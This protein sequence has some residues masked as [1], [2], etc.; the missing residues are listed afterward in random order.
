MAAAPGTLAHV[1]QTRTASAPYL[2]LLLADGC[3]LTCSYCHFHAEQQ[4]SAVPEG[5]RPGRRVM[6]PELVRRAIN[7]FAQCVGERGVAHFDLSL[8]GGEPLVN[9]KGLEAALAAVQ[10]L[11]AGGLSLT[12]IVNTNATL[13]TAALA[14]RLATLGARAHVSLDGPDLESNAQRRLHS[15]AAS[16][17][18]ALRGLV[19][20]HQAGVAMQLNVVITGS[21]LHRL[22]AL[23]ERAHEAGCDQVFLALPDDPV[24]QGVGQPGQVLPALMA[25]RARAL[26]LGISVSGPWTSGSRPPGEAAALPV[27]VVVRPDGRVFRPHFPDRHFEHVAAAIAPDMQ[28]QLQREWR[29][30]CAPCR[31]CAIERECRGYLRMMVRYHAGV[32]AQPDAECQLARGAARMFASPEHERLRTALHLAATPQQDGEWRLQ[33]PAWP[34]AGIEVS[35]GVV[36]LLDFFLPGAT[37]AAAAEIFDAEALA[38]SLAELR[39]LGALQPGTDSDDLQRFETLAPHEAS[40]TRLCGLLLGAADAPT[41]ATAQALAPHLEQA[42]ACLPS[43]L[44]PVVDP[45][46]V[47]IAA[48]AACFARAAQLP[49]DAPWLRWMAGTVASSV[50]VLQGPACVAVLRQGGRTRLRVFQQQLAHELAHVA[51]RQRGLRVPT[52]LEEGLCEWASGATM[53]TERLAGALPHAEAF[54][55]F[56]TACLAGAE[57][58]SPASTLLQFSELPVDDNPGYRLAHDFVD[59]LVRGLGQGFDGLLDALLARGLRGRSAAFPLHAGVQGL[60]GQDLQSLLAAWQAELAARLRPP[61]Q[62]ARPMRLLAFGSRALVYHR[63]IGGPVELDPATAAAWPALQE[64]N[65]EVED[66]EALVRPLPNGPDLLRRWRAGQLAPRRGY[67]LRLTIEGGCNMSCSYCYEGDKKRQAMSVETA[68]RAVAAWRDLLEPRDLPGSTIRVFGGEPFLNWPLMQHLF[69]TATAGLPAGAVRWLVNTNGT[70]IHHEQVAALQALGGD[71]LVYLSMDG[72]GAVNDR[73][74][75]FRNQRGSFERV[76]RAARALVAARVP[77]VIAVTLTPFNAA[78]LPALLD[79]VAALRYQHP[80]APLSVG[81]KPVIGPALQPGQAQ[82]MLQALEAAWAQGRR[83]GLPV[84]GELRVADEMLLA[85]STPTG[86]FCGVTGRELYVTPAGGLMVCH[87]VPDSEYADL[88]SVAAEHRIPVPDDVA[89]RHAGGMAGCAGCEVEGLCGGGCMAQSHAATG[90]IAGKPHDDFCLM[91]RATFRNGV[92]R[93]LEDLDAPPPR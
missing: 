39:L 2:R 42:V 51:L 58:C 30:V 33:H 87:A 80:D 27:S 72:V 15:G 28:E 89:A 36:D 86:H 10:A 62:F 7:D 56:V 48:D 45:I 70:L 14:A 20:L 5:Q 25:A 53:D 61:A 46:A 4:A 64:R 26:A 35:E 84:T 71:V 11:R 69:A 60:A 37:P 93:H 49:D 81:I 83:L 67:H 54:A 74:R 16:L 92:R 19:L 17:S 40:L 44:R 43:R 38:E 23:M 34:A 82:E 3:N 18:A 78:G 66:I 6:S 76:D 75:V 12:P 31:G 50:V 32:Q 90:S 85:D 1:E 57:G 68:D 59:F 9:P 63:I 13:V 88:A 52:W 41:A 77:L 55:E 22:V 29:A 79:H 21:N 65:L 24:G 8:Y 91:M 47:F 73:D